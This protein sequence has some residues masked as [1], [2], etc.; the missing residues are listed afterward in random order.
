MFLNGRSFGLDPIETLVF[1]LHGQFRSSAFH[2]APAEQHVHHIRLE[3]VQQ[4]LVMG[5]AER[6]SYRRAQYDA[7]EP[8]G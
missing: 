3:V 5:D 6:R 8:C 7:D 4:T 1:Y 2:D